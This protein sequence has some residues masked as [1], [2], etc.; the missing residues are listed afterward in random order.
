MVF[1]EAVDIVFESVEGGSGH[2]SGLSEGTAEEFSDATCL[3]DIGLISDEDRPHRAAKALGETDRNGIEMGTDF[4]GGVSGGDGGV[5]KPGTIKMHLESVGPGPLT[6]ASEVFGGV[7][8]STSE[9]GGVFEADEP[10]AGQV[11][12]FGT[13]FSFELRGIQH[14]V[15]PFDESASDTAESGGGTGFKVGDVSAGFDEEF[16][17]RVTMDANS[18]LVRL[19]P[20]AGVDG[21]FLSE[22]FAT[23]L[24]EPVDGGVLGDHVVPDFGCG[25]GSAHTGSRTGDSI[26]AH[27][28]GGGEHVILKNPRGERRGGSRFQG[29]SGSVDWTVRQLVGN[30][31]CNEVFRCVQ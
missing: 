2:H 19:S 31:D 11:L 3:G 14:P 8:V 28:D 20:G 16:V 23:S 18:H 1:L 4:R 5:E 30:V 24:F 17:S 27:V 21:G 9:V 7:A 13:N 15:G 29:E 10:G 12:V 25:D 6:D 22:E 26:A